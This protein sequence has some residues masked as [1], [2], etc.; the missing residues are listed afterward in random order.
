MGPS[1]LSPE[2]LARIFINLPYNSLLSVQAVCVQWKAVTKDPALSIQLFKKPSTEYVE[3]GCPDTKKRGWG[4]SELDLD[5]IMDSDPK[6]LKFK[7]TVPD[8]TPDKIRAAWSESGWKAERATK[9]L[10]NPKWTPRPPPAKTRLHPALN[11]VSY[12]IGN[13]LTDVCF[14]VGDKQPQLSDLSIAADFL[15]IPAVTTA[16]VSCGSLTVKVK[17]SKG[18]KLIDFFKAMAKESSVKVKRGRQTMTKGDLLGDH[19][20]YEGLINV[21]RDGS[22]LAAEIATGS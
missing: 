15:S 5:K 17:N 1:D 6:F 22:E 13:D 8:Y 10:V 12:L 18:I 4:S 3:P 19:R 7:L 9:L 21:R 14:F 20:F 2:V 11:S 16:T